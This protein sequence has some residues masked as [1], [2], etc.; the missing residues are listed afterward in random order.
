MDYWRRFDH[1]DI[2]TN[3]EI[4]RRMKVETDVNKY[5]KVNMAMMVR[6]CQKIAE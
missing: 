6:T 3:T 2:I 1:N 5:I 4:R